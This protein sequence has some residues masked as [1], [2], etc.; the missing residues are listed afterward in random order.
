MFTLDLGKIFITSDA[1]TILKELEIV[2][3]AAK[4]VV[5]ASQQQEQEVIYYHHYYFFFFTIN[6]NDLLTFL[7]CFR[8]EIPPTWCLF[9]QASFYLKLML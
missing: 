2:H 6:L 3:P 8:W 4:L 5:M 1:A 9:L 7:P